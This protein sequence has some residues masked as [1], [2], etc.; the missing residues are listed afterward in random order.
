MSMPK[1]LLFL[2][3]QADLHMDSNRGLS[4]PKES[5]GGSVLNRLQK[6]LTVNN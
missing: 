4:S 2:K 1:R 5:I 6:I 3:P